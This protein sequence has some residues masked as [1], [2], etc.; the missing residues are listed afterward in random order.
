MEALLELSVYLPIFSLK[1][2]VRFLKSIKSA[3]SASPRV[4]GGFKLVAPM[5]TL[6]ASLISHNLINLFTDQAK[7]RLVFFVKTSVLNFER[8]NSI[9]STWGAIKVYKLVLIKVVFIVGTNNDDALK[10]KLLPEA[11]T[12][13]DIL[14]IDLW[15]SSK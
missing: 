1:S 10:T 3:Q 4:F 13:K 11:N 8:R 14:Q 9:R 2:T 15:D 5:L 7:W 6:P 12:Y